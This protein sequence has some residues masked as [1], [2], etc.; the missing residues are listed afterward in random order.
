MLKFRTLA[1]W[2]ACLSLSGAV[3]ADAL[4]LQ[5]EGARIKVLAG[6]LNSPTPMPTLRDPQPS[7]TGGTKVVL[8]SAAGDPAFAAG[9]GD[10]RFTALRVGSDG[11][12]TY[13][14]ARYGRQ[15]T[16]PVNDL[17]LVPTMPG[18]NVFQLYFKGRPAAAS[19]VN[20]E[21]ASGWRKALRPG[22]DGTITLDT[23]MPGLY[24]L[25]VSAKVNN[26]TVSIEGRTYEDVRHTAT[27][28]FEVAR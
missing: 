24:V 12:L 16:K 22:K 17:E 3:Q 21:T 26:A 4:W 10:A 20:V 18:G 28:S 7:Q 8:D 2:A 9:D 23:P 14:H 5:R 27:L 25:E 13:F 11:V 15:E 6:E 19:L 1:V